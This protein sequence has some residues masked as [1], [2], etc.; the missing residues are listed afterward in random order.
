MLK[1]L[2]IFI[3]IPLITAYN[4]C[5]V[6]GSSGLGK[7]LIYQ[8]CVD[9]DLKVLALTTNFDKITTPCRVNS[10]T[11]IKNQPKFS[12][13]N[14]KLENYWD[15]L[16]GLDYDNLI[17]T[18]SAKPFEDDYSDKLMNKIL[19][20]ISGNCKSI[21]LVSAFGVGNSLKKGNLGI[22]AMNAW[23][24]KD[25]Y[26]AKNKQEEILDSYKNKNIK[27][28]LLYRPKALSYGETLLDSISRKDLADEILSKL[29]F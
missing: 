11:E 24:L 9:K 26:R 12:H 4:I 3:S 19:H 22:S 14:L 1:Y 8:S 16:T 7:E 25:V 5:I 18:T 13:P 17:F 28:K 21:S 10:F 2:I 29:N 23:Y 27:K 20:N 15:D 6:G